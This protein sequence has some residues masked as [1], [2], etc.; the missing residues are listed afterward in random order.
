ME[1]NE[2]GRIRR[3]SPCFTIW[4]GY[5]GAPTRPTGNPISEERLIQHLDCTCITILE[6]TSELVAQPIRHSITSCNGVRTLV[7][8]PFICCRDSIGSTIRGL[9]AKIRQVAGNTDDRDAG[10]V[11]QFLRVRIGPI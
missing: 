4:A 9:D 1:R 5:S 8:T 3:D 2:T 11:K 7:R 6:R 10:E